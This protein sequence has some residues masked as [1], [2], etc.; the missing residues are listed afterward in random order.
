M[1]FSLFQSIFHPTSPKTIWG[2]EDTGRARQSPCSQRACILLEEGKPAR[3]QEFLGIIRHVCVLQSLSH[4]RLFAT[5][6]PVACLAPL[7]MEFSRQE[8]QSGLPYPPPG[9]L[10]NSR[11]EPIL[12]FISH[13]GRRILYHW[14]SWEARK[15]HE[16]NQKG[17]GAPRV[18][19]CA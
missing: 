11:T 5:R 16:G 10:P 12:S 13:T 18:R 19:K 14:A 1:E 6:W 2:L 9:D 15:T 8:Y 3:K 17:K 7:S 4:V